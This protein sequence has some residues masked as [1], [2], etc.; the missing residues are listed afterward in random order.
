MPAAPP[1]PGI[2]T[3]AGGAA[4]GGR[5]KAARAA[6]TAAF[7][8]LAVA[9]V[10]AS[11]WALW[12][13]F[14]PRGAAPQG[15]VAPRPERPAKGGE[16]EAP[17]DPQPPTPPS[18][19]PEAALA[20]GDLRLVEEALA[21]DRANPDAH[22]D[23]A[24]RLRRALLVAGDSS[25]AIR[26]RAR[27]AT[28]QQALSVD[29]EGV[30]AEVG[31]HLAA[32]QKQGRF[33]A[34]L[35]ACQAAPASLRHGPWADLLAARFADLGEEAQKQ[36]LTLA[37]RGRAALEAGKLDEGLAL[38]AAIADIGIPWITRAAEPLGAAATAYVEAER[39]RLREA[40]DRRAALGRRRALGTL[41]KHFGL[42]HEE[43]KKLDYAKAL[44]ACKAV[45][46][47][48]RDEHRATALNNLQ[49]RVE[50]LV[51]V[52]E[53]ILK[54]QSAF[55]GKPFSLHGHDYVVEGLAGSGL[56]A[57]MVLRRQ[58][59]AGG[60]PPLRQQVW[61][62]PGPQLV[63]L[64]EWAT[65]RAQ[66]G[67][68]ALKLG[69]L[70]LTVGEAAKAKQ[71]LLEAQKAGED[72]A[73]WLDELEA[74]TVV[75]AALTAYRKGQWAE[76]RKLLESALDHY[77]ATSPAILSHKELTND[78]Q[79]C[80]LKLR[81]PAAPR[82]EPAEL[83]E[84]LSSR[85]LLAETRLG[86]VP[87]ASPLDAHFA[88]PLWRSGPQRLGLDTWDNYKLSLRWTPE[89]RSSVLLG[90]RLGEPQPGVFQYYYVAVGNG[91][92]T[93]GLRGAKGDKVLA[94][95]PYPA[96]AGPSAPHQLTFTLVGPSLSAEMEDGTTLAATESTLT[97]GR[98]LLA[99]PDGTLVV[100]ELLAIWQPPK[101]P[102]P[103]GK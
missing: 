100:H 69:V 20:E 46:E 89:G 85:M 57:L 10:V 33:G 70:C 102:A 41:A 28:R 49:R 45:P 79:D 25:W 68:A 59:D 90:A 11:G 74:E 12:S 94:T 71:K 51:E 27:L 64:A 81:E 34:A 97:S 35:Q 15:S 50:L 91:Q 77:G 56:K 22:G 23:A 98:A 17:R 4:A 32:L 61:S 55:I 82:S 99:A 47:A 26:L 86:I 83:P 16:P 93:L 3:P 66:G 39:A 63:R 87:P 53:A 80:L 73:P 54:G 21:F 76:A 42:V 43:I 40:A 13:R 24:L 52:W 72:V 101:R 78:L 48:D 6:W 36:Y 84:R 62:L 95:K 88:A 103:K 67:A 5:R 9:F 31:E 14:G 30:Y 1:L 37:S 65:E 7:A 19:L 44:D 58:G 2:A 38:Y 60:Q 18:P 29:G 75:A 8:A 92:A 96:S